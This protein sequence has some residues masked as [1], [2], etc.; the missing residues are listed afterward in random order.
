MPEYVQWDSLTKRIINKWY[1]VD[2]S[3]VEGKPNILQIPRNVYHSLTKFHKVENNQ[4]VLMT[5]AEQDALLAEEAEA[6]RQELLARIN[7]YEVSNLDLLTA[8]V[9]R[10]NVRIPSNPITK[11]EIIQQIKDDLGI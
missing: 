11:N 4:V 5:Q 8:L 6:H 7:K 1:S 9:K 10:I 3:I 2:P